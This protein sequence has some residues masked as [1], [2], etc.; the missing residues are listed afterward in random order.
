M[1]RSSTTALILAVLLPYPVEAAVGCNLGQAVLRPK[2]APENFVIIAQ[3]KDA[4]LSF[5]LTVRRTGE[6]FPFKA[7]VDERS[8]TGTITSL[9]YASGRDP[10]IKTTFSLADRNGLATTAS[11][12]VGSVAFLDLARGFIE[13]RSRTGQSP[14]PY[15]NPPSGLWLVTECQALPTVN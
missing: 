15:A 10:A 3:R 12:E 14:S 13:F 1:L 6:T 5:H 2:Y 7:D 9:A 4:D 8:Q 11:G